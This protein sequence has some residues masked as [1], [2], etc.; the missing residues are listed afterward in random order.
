MKKNYVLECEK[1]TLPVKNKKKSYPIH[2]S[3]QKA[4]VPPKIIVPNR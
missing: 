1:H 3:S 4:T 2:N